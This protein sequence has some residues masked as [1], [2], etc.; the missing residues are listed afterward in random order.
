MSPRFFVNNLKD[1]V[2]TNEVTLVVL[3]CQGTASVN[4]KSLSFR[5]LS[6]KS[7]QRTAGIS[8]LLRL[9]VKSSKRQIPMLFC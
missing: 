5:F 1:L 3:K 7:N 9:F 2:I 4:Y 8:I 6:T